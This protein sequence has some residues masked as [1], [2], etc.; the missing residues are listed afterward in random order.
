MRIILFAGKGGVGKTTVAAATGTRC[1]ALG[2]RTLVMSLDTAHSLADSFDLDRPL[3]DRSR[4]LPV[5]VTKDLEIQE[6]DVQ[7]E[8][9]RNWGQVRAY[10]STILNVSGLEEVLAEELAILP[11][12]EEVSILLYLNQ[13]LKE[14]SYDVILLDCAPTGESL[15]FISLP[16]TLEWYM[17]RVF[18]LERSIFRVARPI[19]SGI[20]DVPLPDDAYFQSIKDLWGRLEGVDAVLK[21]PKVTTV[22]LVTNPEKMVIKESQRAFMYFCLYG[23]ALDGIVINRILPREVRD[24]YFEA[25]KKVQE[26]YVAS[27]R[28]TFAPLPAFRVP[29]QAGEVLGIKNLNALGR[30]I[31]ADRDPAEVFTTTRPYR[32]EKRDGAYRLVMALPFVGKEQ[33][34]LNMSGDELIV[35]IGTFKRYVPLPRSYQGTVPTAAQ[36]RNDQ[37]TI[38]FGGKHGGEKSAR[39]SGRGR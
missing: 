12:M 25:W 8:V 39:K 15:R 23:M 6:V 28:E 27:A 30:E 17:R 10:V 9:Q 31:Y 7:E 2:H 24:A 22:R 26:K 20:T 11:G 14:K 38:T 3:M 21:D 13:Y 34:D 1:A 37:L 36:L 29:L 32:F 33:V 35:R 4:G 18:H 16:T 19:L 5:R